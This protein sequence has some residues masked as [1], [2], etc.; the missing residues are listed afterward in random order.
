LQFAGRGV[1]DGTT[2]SNKRLSLPRRVHPSKWWRL[3]W[4]DIA[5]HRSI[6][7][8][9]RLIEVDPEHVDTCIDYVTLSSKS[10]PVSIQ[11]WWCTLL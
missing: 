4:P 5:I 1:L 3:W 8:T 6:L 7:L 2:A 9:I 11:C 10:M